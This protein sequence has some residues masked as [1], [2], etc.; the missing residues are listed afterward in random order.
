MEG[1]FKKFIYT[2][3]GL[4]SLTAERLQKSV[5]ELVSKGKLSEDEGR[6]VVDDLMTET[7]GKREEFESRIRSIVEK[8]MN[9]IDYPSHKEVQDLRARIEVL[10]TRLDVNAAGGNKKA[11]VRK[12]TPRKTSSKETFEG[13]DAKT[14]NKPAF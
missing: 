5:D 13:T 11:A 7:E 3:V 1:L 14:T 9:R 12:V 10:E 6:K 8:V 4:V 2:G